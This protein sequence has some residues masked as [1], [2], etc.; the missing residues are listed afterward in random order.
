MRIPGP[1]ESLSNPEGEVVLFTDVFKRGLRLPLTHSCDEGEE[2][3]S[4]GLG[5][6]ELPGGSA[7]G[8]LCGGG[9]NFSEDLVPASGAGVRNLGIG[10]GVSLKRSI[11]TKREIEV[12][13][14]VRARKLEEDRFHKALLDYKNLYKAGLISELEYLRRKEK[15]KERQSK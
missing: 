11:A 6:V 15:E 5:A 2:R 8:A 14:R 1:L 12:I 9:A 10:T 7:E 13:E 4:R 3:R